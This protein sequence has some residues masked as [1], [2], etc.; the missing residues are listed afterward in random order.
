MIAPTLARCG[1]SWGKNG[2]QAVFQKWY[3]SRLN[4]RKETTEGIVKEAQLEGGRLHTRCWNYSVGQLFMALEKRGRVVQLHGDLLERRG[5]HG[6][7]YNLTERSSGRNCIQISVS[8]E[9][10]NNG[11]HCGCLVR[12]AGHTGP[13]HP[14]E[15]V[16]TPSPPNHGLPLPRH[17]SG[18]R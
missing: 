1:S 4:A 9:C 18:A 5:M 2:A 15:L 6:R 11:W 13:W 17:R 7:R 16:R 10:S 8:L 3:C 12:R 14:F